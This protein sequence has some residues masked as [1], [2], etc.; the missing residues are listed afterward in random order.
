MWRTYPWCQGFYFYFLAGSGKPSQACHAAKG[1]FPL[2][3]IVAFFAD[4]FW[5][6]H[7]G[8]EDCVTSP[9][10]CMGG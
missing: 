6:R 2:A 9:N 7:M 10:V 8:V 1:V 3:T 4:A 5:A